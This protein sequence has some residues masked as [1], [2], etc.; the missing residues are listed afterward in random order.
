MLDG[1]LHF[2]CHVNFLYSRALTTLGL[3]HFINYNFSSLDS[4]VVLYIAL[5]SF[6]IEYASVTWNKLTPDYIIL[7]LYFLLMSLG[8]KLIAIPL[9]TLSIYIPT[10]QIIEF[11]TFSEG[12]AIRQSFSHVSLLQMKYADFLTLLAKTLPLLRTPSLYLKVF[13]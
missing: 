1:K 11:S 13:R 7:T 9:W 12:N 3:I 2:N 8:A 4:L 5:I 10:K 6:K